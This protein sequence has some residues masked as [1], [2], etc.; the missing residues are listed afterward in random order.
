MGRSLRDRHCLEQ[1][2]LCKCDMA[3]KQTA[4]SSLGKVNAGVD[5]ECFQGLA[6]EIR[7][8][9][10]VAAVAEEQEQADTPEETLTQR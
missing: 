3:A 8:Q 5:C 9:E 7:E 6:K 2:L 4:K 10:A 1:D